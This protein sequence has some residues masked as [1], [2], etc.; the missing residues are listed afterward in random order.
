MTCMPSAPLA[1]QLR[2]LPTLLGP[3]PGLEMYGSGCDGAKDSVVADKEHDSDADGSD[4]STADTSE[5]CLPCDYQPGQ[6]M[7]KL[8][9]ETSDARRQLQLAEALPE[10]DQGSL[11][12][13]SIGS[14]GHHLGICKPCDFM[15]RTNCR[16]GYSCQFCHL[17]APGET[18]RRKKQKQVARRAFVQATQAAQ[19]AQAA[20][21]ATAA[22][23]WQAQVSAV[24][25]QFLASSMA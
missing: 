7:K 5:V 19:A 13:P 8:A 3:P 6:V 1:S 15:Y 17:C 9:A 21:A 18:R 10:E 16:A 14:A 11:D 22:Q 4:C 24:Q 25:M 20:H 23:L 2:P 12:C